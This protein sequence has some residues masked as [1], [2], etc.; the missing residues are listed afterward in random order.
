MVPARSVE[1]FP[2]PASGLVEREIASTG[3]HM[4]F[5][6]PSVAPGSFWAADRVLEWLE[7]H[8]A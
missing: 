2:L 1:Q 5:V 8:L 3:G 4:G 6:A 7:P